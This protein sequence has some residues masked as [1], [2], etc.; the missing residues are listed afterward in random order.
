MYDWLRRIFS[1]SGKPAPKLNSTTQ[2]APTAPAPVKTA[3]FAS[4]SVSSMQRDQVDFIFASWL[5]DAESHPDIFTNG[6]ENAILAALD[7]VVKSNESGAHLV[8]RMPGVIPQLLQ[9]LRSGD[10]AG[11]ELARK[12][13]TDLVLVAEVLRL[14][15][16]VAYST[17]KPITS[18]DHAILVLGQDGLRQLITSVAFKPIINLKSGSF[19]KMVAPRLWAQSE[20]CA[21][22]NRLLAVDEAV[23]PL[24]V[25]LAGLV[26]NVGLTVSLRVIDQISDGRQPVGSPTFC[27]ALAAYGRTLAY[28]IGT[29]WHFP[30]SVMTAIREQGENKNSAHLSPVG[31]VLLMGNYLSK[32]ELLARHGALDIDDPRMIDGLSDKE[33][34]CLRQLTQVEEREWVMV[35]GAR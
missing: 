22:A 30:E 26:Q 28:N 16:S 19:T 12:I 8:R 3:R 35:S 31:K 1:D 4:D 15:N 10:F 33:A 7:G 27:N 5:F 25:F 29:E 17:G 34:D 9:S 2:A 24:E 18:I 32:L 6:N 11:A 14:A 23:E 20:R 21:L 13:S